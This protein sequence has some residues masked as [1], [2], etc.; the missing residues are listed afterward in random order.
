VLSTLGKRVYNPKD[1]RLKLWVFG[2]D[3]DNMKACC[4]YEAKM[5]IF[6]KIE[7]L[8]E[9]AGQLIDAA[10]EVVKYLRIAIKNAW[11]NLNATSRGNFD[12]INLDFWGKTEGNFYKKLEKFSVEIDIDLK[13]EWL[14]ELQSIANQMFHRHTQSR[15]ADDRRRAKASVQFAKCLHGPKLRGILGLAVIPPSALK[16]QLF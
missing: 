13:E 6:S 14:E 1:H 16:F 7:G 3:M 5:P 8:S 9:F 11:F 15:G 2:Y 10:E 12:F 4:W